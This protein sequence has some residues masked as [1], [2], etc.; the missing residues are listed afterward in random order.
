MLDIPVPPLRIQSYADL[1]PAVQTKPPEVL[2]VADEPA[3]EEPD[4]KVKKQIGEVDDEPPVVA[5]EPEKKVSIKKRI[6]EVDGEESDKKIKIKKLIREVNVDDN[7]NDPKQI[8]PTA[9]EDSKPELVINPMH[10]MQEKRAKKKF[11][12]NFY[13]PTDGAAEDVTSTS[14][15]AKI[16]SFSF[17]EAL[18]ETT[19]VTLAD[20]TNNQDLDVPN[21]SSSTFSFTDALNEIQKTSAPKNFDLSRCFSSE[22]V[23]ISHKEQQQLSD[24][25]ILQKQK[26][27]TIQQEI[28]DAENELRLL[29]RSE[30]L[31]SLI[32]VEDV[33]DKNESAAAAAVVGYHVSL[34]ENLEM[35]TI[36]DRS[37]YDSDSNYSF[38]D[39]FDRS[40]HSVSPSSSPIKTKPIPKFDNSDFIPLMAAVS[41]TVS[42]EIDEENTTAEGISHVVTRV[43]L[44]DA[45]DNVKC[46]AK[47]FL[48]KDHSKYLLTKNGNAFLTETFTRHNVIVRMEWR[49]I[50]NILIVQGSTS[51][52][53]SFHA[54]LIQYCSHAEKEARKKQEISQQ[55]PKNRQALIRFIKDQLSIL[56]KDQG[57]VKDLFIKMRLSE[58]QNSKA[59]T[60]RA[61]QAR[62]SLNIILMG[63]T[64]LRDGHM[65][66]TAL[67]S[68][69]R[70]L[71]DTTGK[72]DD[73]VGGP[74]S[75]SFRN[76]VF[77]H[78]RYIF[79]SVEHPDYAHLIHEYD[80]LRRNKKL[81]TLNLDPSL[82]GLKINVMTPPPPPPLIKI[83]TTIDEDE[84]SNFDEARQKLSLNKDQ[85][86]P[87]TTTTTLIGAVKRL[88]PN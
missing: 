23:N 75:T 87:T 32:E 10:L 5:D 77:Q 20:T 30:E 41:T 70:C 60:K 88:T 6:R 73:N 29:N 4:Q 19:V 37:S 69:L 56:V 59:G 52:Q 84:K 45:S 62:R 51:S 31:Q 46:E 53:D 54:D 28:A 35:G 7:G 55:V 40:Q 42:E 49:S 39:F 14:E 64:G 66:L 82:V 36:N 71:M 61:D 50:G 13:E 26:K 58:R 72:N 85:R 18:N 79:S 57:K 83:D 9:P 2:D 78:F 44:N 80:E 86:K 38:S 34:N 76:E 8:K 25:M 63:Q 12:K 81:P 74:I 33:G 22:E 67:Q 68:N 43:E 11:A 27:L 17:L 15:S 3:V 47:I 48:T 16:S 24:S 65:H 1:Y 21:N